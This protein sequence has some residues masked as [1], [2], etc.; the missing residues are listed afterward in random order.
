MCILITF[1]VTVEII[2]G[3]SVCTAVMSTVSHA[4]PMSSSAAIYMM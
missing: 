1:Q 3:G 4:V 2:E